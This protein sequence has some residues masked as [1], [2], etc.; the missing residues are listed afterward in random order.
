MMKTRQRWGLG[1]VSHES[2]ITMRKNTA[3][4]NVGNSIGPP[5]ASVSPGGVGACAAPAGPIHQTLVLFLIGI[6][7]MHYGRGMPTLKPDPTFYPSPRSAAEAPAE[8]L[9]YVVTLNTGTNG[10]RRPDALTVVDL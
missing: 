6:M 4:V 7:H 3:N 5:R 1:I 10:D 9:A 2:G 8:E